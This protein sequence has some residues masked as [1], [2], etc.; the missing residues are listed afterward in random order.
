M[1]VEL[2]RPAKQV[3]LVTRSGTWLANRVFAGIPADFAGNTRFQYFLPLSVREAFSAFI[4]NMM[5]SDIGNFGLQPTHKALDAH[6]TINGELVGRIVVGSV[7]VK[8]NIKSFVGSNGLEFD[9]GYP[10]LI[11]LFLC[12]SV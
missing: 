3:Y 8:P 10:R 4:L 5:N 12:V 7:I 2:S 1:A 9:D 11:I 6:P